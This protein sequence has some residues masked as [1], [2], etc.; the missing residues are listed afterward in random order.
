MT[1][2]IS[3]IMTASAIPMRPAK[4]V[5]CSPAKDP[6]SPKSKNNG[7]KSRPM[8]PYSNP[9][10]LASHITPTDLSMYIG[11]VLDE[12][13]ENFGRWS[14]VALKMSTDKHNGITDQCVRHLHC[15]IRRRQGFRSDCAPPFADAC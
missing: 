10:I 9:R 1:P 12:L 7:T 14:A 13:V 6:S 2:Y 5:F 15:P 8:Q 3:G 4:G 11:C